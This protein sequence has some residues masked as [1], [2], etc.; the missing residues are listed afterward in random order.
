MPDPKGRNFVAIQ[1]L[2]RFTP[3]NDIFILGS[4][5][6]VGRDASCG[7]PRGGGF[8]PHGF[9]GL[10]RKSS[11]GHNLKNRNKAR[12]PYKTLCVGGATARAGPKGRKFADNC[13][14]EELQATKNLKFR[15]TD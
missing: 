13:H 9:A 11:G 1:I 7:P 6:A 15:A 14:S 4:K 8:G 2:R 3:Q 10:Q 5:P 12:R